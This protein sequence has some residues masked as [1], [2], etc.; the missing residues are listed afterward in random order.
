L[1]L[2]VPS[3]FIPYQPCFLPWSR[4]TLVADGV[5]RFSRPSN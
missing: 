3:S 2:Y 1:L 4:S 5:W